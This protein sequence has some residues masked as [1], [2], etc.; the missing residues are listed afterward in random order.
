[1]GIDF[2]KLLTEELTYKVPD[3]I[4]SNSKGKR[5]LITGAAGSIG[6]SVAKV[7]AQENCCRLMLLDQSESGLYELQQEL[8]LNRFSNFDCVIAS[9]TQKEVLE[10]VFLEFSP[11]I[12]IHTAAY[13]HV[14]L[15]EKFPYQSVQV[16]VFGTKIIADLAKKYK[17]ESF[18]FASTDKAVN[19][20][21]VMGATKRIAELYVAG[22]N[23]HQHKIFK[24]VRFGNVPFSSGSVIPLFK[25]QLQFNK[26]ITVTNQ[27][28][29]RYFISMNKV[30]EIILEAMVENTCDLLI[31]EMGSP[32]SIEKLAEKIIEKEGLKL[33]EV[34]IEKIGIRPGEKISEEIVYDDEI[35]VSACDNP[36]KKYLLKIDEH[37]VEK[38]EKLT[39]VT[40]EYSNEKILKILKEI[41]P[42]YK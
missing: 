37:I 22:L 13:K 21:G 38:V 16:N 3:K 1:M 41:V 23:N 31:Y 39:A 30:C 11:Q 36:I 6:S 19:P 8:F 17:V 32:V 26:K 24:V 35:D 15:M 20:R 14:P 18:V 9:I 7:I 10:K 27:V 5:I 33:N 34:T 25:K 12:V 42:Q 4:T 29:S 28:I 40:A 2:D